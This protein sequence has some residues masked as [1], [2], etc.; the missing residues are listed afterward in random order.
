MSDFAWYTSILLD[1]AVMPGAQHGAEVANQLIEVALR[2]DTVRPYAVET[3]LSMLL[4]D[5][6]VL[7]QARATV[8]EVL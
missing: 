1:L 3:M 5:E 2:V 7:G 4:N 6:L 8:C